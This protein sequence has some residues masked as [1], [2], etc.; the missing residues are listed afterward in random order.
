MQIVN[1]VVPRHDEY[2]VETH[3]MEEDKAKTVS[4]FEVLFKERTKGCTI[5]LIK[6]EPDLDSIKLIDQFV[7]ELDEKAENVRIQFSNCG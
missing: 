7:F 4:N 5:R 1:Y 6:T 2:V 3:Y